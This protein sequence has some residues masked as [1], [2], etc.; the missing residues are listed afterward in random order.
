M[1]QRLSYN[2][3]VGSLIPSLPSSYCRCTLGQDASLTL[4]QLWCD[5]AL[6][7]LKSPSLAIIK[8]H[9]ENDLALSITDDL[10][11]SILNRVHSSSICARHG[12]LQFKV[13]YRLHMSKEKL[14]SAWKRFAII[15]RQELVH[16]STPS[17][18]V[19]IFTFIGHLPYHDTIT[20]S[21]L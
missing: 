17:G 11:E 19:P 10:W 1:V 13:L 6:L 9:W 3:K 7:D 18:Y 12:L 4:R 21:L 20:K 8:S 2:R 14:V 5:V 16:L 15:V